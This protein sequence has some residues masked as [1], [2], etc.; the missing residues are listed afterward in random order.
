MANTLVA[1]FSVSGTTE[2]V[3]RDLASVVGADLFEIVPEIPYTRADL[4]WNDRE[5]RSTIEMR[6][7]ACRP[8]IAG[9]VADMASYD[10]VYVGFPVW[11]YIEPRIID[12]FLESYDFTGKTIIPFATSG[13]SDLGKAPQRMQQ[14]APG[15]KVEAGGLLNGRPGKSVLKSWAARFH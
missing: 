10:T 15:A 8:A 5:S 6:D 14:L 3:A 4:N 1:Y 11:W 2:K 7:E 13:G 12:T 9:K